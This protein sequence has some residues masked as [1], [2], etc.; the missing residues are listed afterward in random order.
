ML[1]LV[2][3]LSEQKFT[4]PPAQF[5]E[6]TPGKAL[7]ENGIGRPS[8][9]A[10]ILSVLTDRDYVER[11]EGRFRPTQLGRLVNGML[12]TGLP[13]HPQRGLHGGAGGAARP[14]RGR[15]APVEAGD[16]RLRRE[17]HQGPGDGRRADAQRQARGHPDRRDCP[18]CGS[19]PAHAL[20]PLRPVHRLQQLSGVQVHPQPRGAAAEDSPAGGRTAAEEEVPPCECCGKPMALKRSRFGTFYGCTG[21]PECKGIRKTGPKR[22]RRSRP[23]SPA[24]SAARARSRRSARAGARPSGPA[25]ATRTASSPSGRS[26]S[27]RSARDCGAPFLLEKVTKKP[28]PSSSATPRA[29]ATSRPKS[30]PKSWSKDA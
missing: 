28:A 18:D 15:P 29:A 10:T 21:Y 25:T 22:R 1:E 6:A 9:Y 4:Q 26:R 27:P 20:R 3:L 12:Q 14:D 17:V 23:A 24:R 8:T 2:K 16:R 13:R 30:R 7:E 19:R 11:V 5:S